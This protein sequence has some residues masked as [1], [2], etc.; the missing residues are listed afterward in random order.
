MRYIKQH[1]RIF[2]ANLLTNGKLNGY[3]SDIKEKTENM[4]TSLV[5]QLIENE[6]ITE[7]LKA[8]NPILWVQKMNNVRNQAKEVVNHEIIYCVK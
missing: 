8:T 3:I 5:K 6:N 7:N 2:Y 1:R 4:F